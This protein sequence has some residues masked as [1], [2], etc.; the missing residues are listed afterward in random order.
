M[1]TRFTLALANQV[2]I[3]THLR[4]QNNFN[5]VFVCVAS[6]FFLVLILMLYVSS[7][8]G[9]QNDNFRKSVT[10]AT[11]C[12]KIKPKKVVLLQSFAFIA[13]QI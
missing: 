10:T 12:V 1:L 2:E 6:K 7:G 3:T 8:M 13:L 4:Q 9:F 5:V 11:I